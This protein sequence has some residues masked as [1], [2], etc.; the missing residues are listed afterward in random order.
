MAGYVQLPDGSYYPVQDGVSYTDAIRTAYAKYPEAFGEAKSPEAGPKSGDIATLLGR[1]GAIDQETAEKYIEEQKK[2]QAR[3]FKPTETFSE[4][5][6]TKFSELLMGSVPYMAAP[7]VAGAAAAALPVAAPTAAVLGL[8][9]AGAA[10]YGQFT[11]SFLSRQMDTGKKLGETE[12]GTAALAALPAAAL[13]TISLRMIPGIRGILGAA[14]KEVTEAQ[15]KAIAQQNLGRTF[16][17][18]VAKAGTK[19]L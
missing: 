6:L 9:A 4:A 3:T 2:Y 11:G 13:D 10:S 7:V 15:A 12:L 16:G 8:G 18:Y 14:G 5:P 17:D 1:T 19:H